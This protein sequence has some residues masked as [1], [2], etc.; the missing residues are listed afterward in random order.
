RGGRDERPARA[1]GGRDGSG[2]ARHVGG[3]G[4]PPS[5]GATESPG[6][7]SIVGIPGVDARRDRGRRLPGAAEGGRSDRAPDDDPS[8]RSPLARVRL[9]FGGR[10]PARREREVSIAGAVARFAITGL[11]GLA[12]L[13]FVAIQLL[14]SRGTS[15]A[16]RNA[17]SLT[18]LA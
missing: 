14:S 3:G 18:Q 1:P 4:N 17:K 13:T 10:R 12:L 11:A 6:R 2:H 9:P 8:R 7:R 15:E 5:D 16:I